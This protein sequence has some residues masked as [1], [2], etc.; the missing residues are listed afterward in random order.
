MELQQHP[1]DPCSDRREGAGNPSL[2]S[3]RSDAAS[4]APPECC[5][6]RLLAN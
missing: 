3:L 4:H 6:A 5:W 2:L 1:D